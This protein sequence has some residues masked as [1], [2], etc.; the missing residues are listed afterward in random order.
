MKLLSTPELAA[1]LGV[2]RACVAQW[3]AEKRLK[4]FMTL[5]NGHHLWKPGTKK[6]KPLQNY[7]TKG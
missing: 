5:A 6:P 3:V 4:P 2:S 1:K 7:P